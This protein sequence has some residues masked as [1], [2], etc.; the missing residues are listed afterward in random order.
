MCGWLE[1]RCRRTSRSRLADRANSFR[2]FVPISNT[3][4]VYIGCSTSSAS[5]SAI[6]AALPAECCREAGV[7]GV[8]VVTVRSSLSGVHDRDAAGV[9]AALLLL[10]EGGGDWEPELVLTVVLFLLPRS[11]AAGDAAR[12]MGARPA[13]AW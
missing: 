8:E 4:V 1:L 2:S 5:S 10:L 13:A 12:A 3:L 11:A 9:V 7:G 6:S